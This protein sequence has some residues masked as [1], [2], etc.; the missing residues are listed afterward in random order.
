[1]EGYSKFKKEMQSLSISSEKHCL[2]PGMYSAVETDMASNG[3]EHLR[4]LGERKI[5]TKQLL[6]IKKISEGVINK[7]YSDAMDSL[8]ILTTNQLRSTLVVLKQF[9][10]W[11]FTRELMKFYTMFTK[12][13]VRHMHIT[14]FKRSISYN[15]ICTVPDDGDVNLIFL[16]DLTE[17]VMNKGGV[18]SRFVEEIEHMID[19][20]PQQTPKKLFKRLNEDQIKYLH[21]SL[22]EM[23]L[24]GDSYKDF[25]IL[26]GQEMGNIQPITWIGEEYELRILLVALKQ[27]NVTDKIIV[28]NSGLYFVNKEGNALKGINKPK[29]EYEDRLNVKILILILEKLAII[30]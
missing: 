23:K 30:S 18:Y 19:D 13:D 9:D 29:K 10:F 28:E 6:T 17:E 26:F 8:M 2:I 24:I 15:F 5:K 20:A 22:S 21:K 1:M 11:H 14:D 27:K 25:S 7:L 16:H 12:G 4:A 3:P